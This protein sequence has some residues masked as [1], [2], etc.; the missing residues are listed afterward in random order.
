LSCDP[1][2]RGRRF[3][4]VSIARYTQGSMKIAVLADIHG[5]LAALRAV[6]DDIDAWSPDLV[7]VAG[8][9]VNLARTPPPVWSW[10]CGS[11][12]RAAGA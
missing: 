11:S 1:R 6:I 10:R 4:P 7:L 3:D 2:R 8:D 9:I 5:N 12:E